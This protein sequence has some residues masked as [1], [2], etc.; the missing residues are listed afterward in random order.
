MAPYSN[1]T[2]IDTSARQVSSKCKSRRGASL[3]NYGLVVGLIAVVAIASITS[4]GDSIDGLFGTVDTELQGVVTEQVASAAAPEPSASA[5][6]T[7]PLYA[8]TTQT[9]DSCGLRGPNGPTV[10]QCRNDGQYSESWT[11]DDNFFTVNAGIQQ[12]TVPETATY[13]IEARGASQGS[14]CSSAQLSADFNLTAGDVIQI[15]V[16]Q[17]SDGVAGNGGTFVATSDN[18]PLIVAGGGGGRCTNNTARASLS[19]TANSGDGSSP[20]A[21]GSNGNGGVGGTGA[22]APGGGGFFTN[23]TMGTYTDQDFGNGF[24]Q[25]GQGGIPS[26]SSPSGGFGGGAS[27]GDGGHY[28][29]GGGYSG[30]GG[31]GNGGSGSGGGGASFSANPIISSSL[32]S[33]ND[34]GRVVITKQ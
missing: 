1:R 2:Q 16:G 20:G 30:G 31:S 32:S 3:V 8:F 18:T 29:G 26:D 12:W 25:G 5:A 34:D 11:D 22:G 13:R 6:P 19:T 27:G 7:G 33:V 9:F 23:G 15:L 21:G 14:S 4:I 28:G 24:V 17:R 10:T